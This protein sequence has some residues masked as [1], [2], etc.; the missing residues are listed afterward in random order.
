MRSERLST[1][2]ERTSLQSGVVGELSSSLASN[3]ASSSCSKSLSS[4]LVCIFL[5][6]RKLLRAAGFS[7][8]DLASFLMGGVM[9]ISESVSK[10]SSRDAS[11]DV[12]LQVDELSDLGEVL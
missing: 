6:L 9:S 12:R 10:S 1:L 8:V 5:T 11:M 4:W 7:T 2:L 3:I